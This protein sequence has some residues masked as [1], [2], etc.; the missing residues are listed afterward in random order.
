MGLRKKPALYAYGYSK[1]KKDSLIINEQ[2]V[3]QMVQ[4]DTDFAGTK[5]GTIRRMNYT[6]TDEITAEV[7]IG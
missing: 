1:D 2:E 4:I 7:E 3:G 6:F 5:T